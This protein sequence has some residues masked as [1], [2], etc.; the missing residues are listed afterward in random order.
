MSKATYVRQI[1]KK[2][3][4]TRAGVIQMLKDESDLNLSPT[5]IVRVISDPQVDGV[6]KIVA[7]DF[8]CIAYLAGYKEPFGR[9]RSEND[10]EVGDAETEESDRE[11]S[12]DNFFLS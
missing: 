3:P 8:S 9:T 5:N 10:F 1:A 12:G 6:W 2:Y 4:D 7:K 11:D